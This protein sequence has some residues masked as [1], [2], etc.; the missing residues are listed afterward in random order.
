MDILTH[1]I[2]GTAMA[3]C[4]STFVKT[5]PLRRAKILLVGTLGGI[6]PDL[7]AIS[8]W[9]QFDR[10]FG[11]LFQLSYKG[12]EIY[13]MK[14]W[15]SHHAFLHSFVSS[16]F[17]GTLLMT[18]IYL[19]RSHKKTGVE[20]KQTFK[21]THIIYFI[22][23]ILGYWAHLAGDLPTPS[24]AWGG[25]ALW[26][27]SDNYVGGLGKIWWWNNYDV[28]LLILTC[29]FIILIVPLLS[30]YLKKHQRLFSVTILCITFCLIMIQINTRKYDYSTP[31]Q[32]AQKEQASQKEQE[33]ILG[34]RIYRAMV[35]FDSKLKFYF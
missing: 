16:V 35:W 5:T 12:K 24:S 34:K 17:L 27:P 31:G 10:T 29:V 4:T 22:T 2:S 13:S 11:K 9:S 18:I 8:L 33:R 21:H 1:A 19:I 20:P 23:F 30:K 6:L 14:L 25:I 15:Y 26:W 7:D 32:Y 28:F 3:A